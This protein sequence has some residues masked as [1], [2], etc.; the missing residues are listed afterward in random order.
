VNICN[1]GDLTCFSF[2]PRKLL[3]SGEG[4]MICTSNNTYAETLTIKLMHGAIVI[5]GKWNFVDYGFNYRLPE[6]QCMMLIKQLK[7][8][9]NI[10]DDRVRIHEY[11]KDELEDYGFKAQMYSTESVHNMQSIVF[12]VPENVDRDAL[13][14]Y[15]KSNNIEAVL[16]TYCLSNCEYYRKKYSDVQEN[17]LWLQEN[18]ISLPCYDAVDT[19]TVIDTIKNYLG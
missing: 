18:T 5:D 6:I 8:L 1:I 2:H 14:G 17:A 11:Y 19:Q 3:T 13:I 15:L 4:G 10:I 12:T 7:K 16:G 9:D